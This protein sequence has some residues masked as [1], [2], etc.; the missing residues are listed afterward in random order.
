MSEKKYAKGFGI[1][2]ITLVC[3]AI[4]FY[5]ILFSLF[6]FTSRWK[7]NVDD[8]ETYKKDF[9]VVASFCNDYILEQSIQN[10]TASNW[11]SYHNQHLYYGEESI[12][13]SDELQNSLYRISDAFKHKDAKL[14][15]IR[16]NGD[17][18]YFCTHNG[19][20][21]L[22]YSPGNKPTSVNDKAEEDVFVKEISNGWFHVVKNNH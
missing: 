20:Y 17:V 22:V 13:L 19:Q 9:E 12:D 11:F 3:L 7:Y 1:V 18:V 8:F 16:C 10:T 6:T 15:I 5:I 2:C 21:S 4:A 14:D